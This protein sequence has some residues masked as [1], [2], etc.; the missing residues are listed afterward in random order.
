MASILLGVEAE[1]SETLQ[2]T[3]KSNQNYMHDI[4]PIV[5]K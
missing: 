1:I 5:G 4:I 2:N 3:G